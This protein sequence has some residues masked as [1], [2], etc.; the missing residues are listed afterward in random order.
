MIFNDNMNSFELEHHIKN[1]DKRVVI[2]VI[3]VIVIA[4]VLLML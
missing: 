4:A 2:N 1:R 3:L